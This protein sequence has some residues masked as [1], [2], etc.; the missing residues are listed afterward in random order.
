VV[1]AVTLLVE[2]PMSD[3]TADGEPMDVVALANGFDEGTLS[4]E[5]LRQW[6][7]YLVETGLVDST[8]TF[9]RFVRDMR[10]A[11]EID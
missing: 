7:R 6:A 1:G 10:E 8:G 3:P 2:D 11:G 9:Q 5:E 4:A